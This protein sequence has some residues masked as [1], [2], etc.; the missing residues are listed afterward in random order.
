MVTGQLRD[1]TGM[2]TGRSRDDHGLV[3][4]RSQFGHATVTVTDHKQAEYCKK[5]F[6][7]TYFTVD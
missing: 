6:V 3:T 4:R 5:K 7:L 2:V 1:C